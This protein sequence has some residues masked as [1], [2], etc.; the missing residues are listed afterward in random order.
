MFSVGKNASHTTATK[1]RQIK[2]TTSNGM[3]APGSVGNPAR[4]KAGTALGRLALVVVV[5]VLLAFTYDCRW[6]YE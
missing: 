4:I 3:T 2:M 1:G 6:Y 5:K